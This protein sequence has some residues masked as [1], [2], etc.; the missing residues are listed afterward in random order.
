MEQEADYEVGPDRD[1]HGLH[2]GDTFP[3]CDECHMKSIPRLSPTHRPSPSPCS[4]VFLEKGPS[5]TCA[6]SFHQER[7]KDRLGEAYGGEKLGTDF[8][9]LDVHVTPPV[10]PAAGPRPQSA[11]LIYHS[12]RNP[13]VPQPCGHG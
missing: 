2:K 3:L 13:P 1:T 6:Q 9:S 7:D 12:P 4:V 5:P 10:L 11:C 8:P